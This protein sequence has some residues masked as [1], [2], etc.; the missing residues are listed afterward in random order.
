MTRTYKQIPEEIG[1]C[2]GNKATHKFL[3]DAL[4]L[5]SRQRVIDKYH[6]DKIKRI[7]DAEG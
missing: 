1:C 2:C 7:I 3:L 5:N 4:P 6:L